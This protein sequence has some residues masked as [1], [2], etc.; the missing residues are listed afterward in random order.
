MK[1]IAAA[2]SAAFISMSAANA[3]M[4]D[5]RMYSAALALKA[6][7][8]IASEYEKCG[9]DHSRLLGTMIEWASNSCHASSD[10]VAELRRAY[11]D[12]LK[13]IAGEMGWRFRRCQWSPEQTRT[14]FESALS[15]IECFTRSQCRD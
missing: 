7:A 13:E 14:E 4:N 2:L 6:T 9:F 11:D 10:Q 3:E 8:M 12:K 1:R 5:D 15:T